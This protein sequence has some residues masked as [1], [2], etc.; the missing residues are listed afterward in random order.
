[1]STRLSTSTIFD[2]QIS[3][4]SRTLVL[5]V[6][7]RQRG[8]VHGIKWVC[9]VI[10]CSLQS[11]IEKSFSYSISYSYSNLKSSHEISCHKIP[12]WKR[13]VYG[14][15]TKYFKF[16]IYL[17]GV[18]SFDKNVWP[19]GRCFY[20]AIHFFVTFDTFKWLYLAYCWVYLHL[21]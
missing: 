13:S 7:F 14:Q 8:V 2:F 5:P 18:E 6:G 10:M 4:V 15:H 3:D 21:R 9:V 1:M 16:D 19:S 11:R 17:D 12:T 20:M